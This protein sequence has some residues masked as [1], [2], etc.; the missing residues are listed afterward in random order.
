MD[1]SV[2]KIAALISEG[3]NSEAMRHYDLGDMIKTHDSSSLKN[4]AEQQSSVTNQLFKTYLDHYDDINELNA[5]IIE[6]NSP[7]DNFSTKERAEVIV[8]AMQTML[9]VQA[10]M[11]SLFIAA[12]DDCSDGKLLHWDRAMAY[13]IGSIEGQNFGGDSGNNGVSIYGLSK[14]MCDSFNVC[15][16]SN[17]AQ[18][19]VHLLAAFSKGQDLISSKS[20]AELTTYVEQRIM[21]LILVPLI[22]ATIKYAD[23]NKPA[24]FHVIGRAISPFLELVS[25][26]AAITIKHGSTYNGVYIDGIT[27]M[28]AFNETLSKLWVD[29]TDVGYSVDLKKGMCDLIDSQQEQSYSLAD[30]LYVTTTFVESR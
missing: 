4:L 17:D 8:K 3:A 13:L 21:P 5:N 20:C 12:Y 16:G 30:G 18:V 6:G 7:F 15:T 1:R 11:S 19:N 23:E 25:P 28:T 24:I 10:G 2:L 26:Q 27:T 22:Q 9:F 29:C 14:E